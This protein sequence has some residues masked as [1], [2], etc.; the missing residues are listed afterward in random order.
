V[1]S[2]AETCSKR[3]GVEPTLDLRPFV[4]RIVHSAFWNDLPQIHCLS[5]V[6]AAAVVAAVE[7][8]PEK[9]G[10]STVPD[11]SLEDSF[12]VSLLCE[13]CW[14]FPKKYLYKSSC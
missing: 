1:K 10:N 9:N 6:A 2:V 5:V 7:E 3:R 14:N 4:D 11:G 13:A 8:E 12:V